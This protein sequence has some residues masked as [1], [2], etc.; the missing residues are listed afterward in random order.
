M[1]ERRYNNYN[2]DF[3]HSKEWKQ[4]R[5]Q[6]LERDLYQCQECLK[7]GKHT[8]ATTVHHVVPIRADR[9]EALRVD[10]LETVC[11]SCHNL[12]HPEKLKGLKAKQRINKAHKLRG[13]IFHANPEN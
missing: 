3:Y 7:H 13:V 5:L 11:P 10:N 2:N 1:S 8:F 12:L 9:S 4:L 6:A